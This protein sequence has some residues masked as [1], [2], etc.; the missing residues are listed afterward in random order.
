MKAKI[1]SK[2]IQIGNQI[3]RINADE[4]WSVLAFGFA[5]GNISGIPNW[6]YISVPENKVPKEVKEMV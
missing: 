5:I 2:S 1:I 4:S 6:H 3:W